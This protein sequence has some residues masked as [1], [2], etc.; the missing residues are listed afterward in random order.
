[1]KRE[2]KFRAWDIEEGV[3]FDPLHH[4]HR[5]FDEILARDYRYSVMQ[6]T[7]LTDKNGKDVFEGDVIN[8]IM[9]NGTITRGTVI[10]HNGSF[11]AR[12]IGA[13]WLIDDLYRYDNTEVVGNIWENPELLNS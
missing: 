7:G 9:M 11:M 5:D 1:M 12:Q 8:P 10:F 13:E 6:F 2:I 4:N 3:M